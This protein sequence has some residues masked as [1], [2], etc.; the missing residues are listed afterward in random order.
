MP[1]TIS[2]PPVKMR[3][4]IASSTHPPA[5]EGGNGNWHPKPIGQE[6]GYKCAHRMALIAPQTYV[7][8]GSSFQ[9]Y[10]RLCRV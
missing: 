7:F 5:A 10:P 8:V 9:P 4:V 2:V 3:G 1:A 6:P